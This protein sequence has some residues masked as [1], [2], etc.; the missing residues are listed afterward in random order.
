MPEEKINKYN[1]SL[2]PF[3]LSQLTPTGQSVTE[4]VRMIDN[5][6]NHQ[7]NHSHAVGSTVCFLSISTYMCTCV[8]GVPTAAMTLSAFVNRV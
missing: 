6:V 7:I 2:K 4:S 5:T 1:I 3:G 8:S